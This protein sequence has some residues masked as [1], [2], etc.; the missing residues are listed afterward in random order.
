MLDAELPMKHALAPRIRDLAQVESYG[1]YT[2][3][4]LHKVLSFS[5]NGWQGQAP[6]APADQR[7]QSSRFSS[8]LEADAPHGAVTFV[9]AGEEVL[10]DRFLLAARS[11]YFDTMLRPGLLEGNGAPVTI[12]GASAAAFRAVLRFVYDAG[13]VD[14]AALFADADP[15]EVLH[16]SVEF[17]LKDLTALCAWRLEADL[18]E[19]RDVE[20]ALA[21]FASVHPLREQAPGV[22]HACV[23]ILGHHMG[24]LP[25][26]AVAGLC[27]QPGATKDL[28]V[29]LSE[30]MARRCRLWEELWRE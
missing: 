29:A 15:L 3:Y 14:P 27:R 16:L 7:L 1:Q 30:P 19:E 2:R 11:E 5:R 13:A 21:I 12:P 28:L 6:P 22:A 23:A 25:E 17:L 9:V 10:A 20:R 18:D 4:S 26:A 8:L 24:E